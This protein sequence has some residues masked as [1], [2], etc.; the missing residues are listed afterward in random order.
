MPTENEEQNKIQQCRRVLERLRNESFNQTTEA[1]LASHA[2]IRAAEEGTLTLAQKRAFAIE[3]FAIQKSDAISFAYLAGHRGF[4]PRSLSTATVPTDPEVKY[5]KNNDESD[6]FQF[7]LG[8]EIYAASLL[9][10]CANFFGM[11]GE[12]TIKEQSQGTLSPLAQAYPSYWARLALNNQRAAAAAA[13]AVNF[14]AW[15]RMCQ[16]LL[17][18]LK[19][20][21]SNTEDSGASFSTEEVDKGLAFIQ[22]FAT[23]IDNL[24][25]MAVAIMAQEDE[26]PYDEIAEHVRLLQEYELLFWDACYNAK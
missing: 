21:K 15:G 12:D 8:G 25:D 2:Y 10:D 5:P 20:S 11:D 24:D 19:K 14:P 18:A 1:K 7:L 13:C 16:K 9:L 23:P 6:L 22:F 26:L 4:L 17:V 3:Q